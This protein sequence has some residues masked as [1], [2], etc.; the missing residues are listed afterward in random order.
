MKLSSTS[1]PPTSSSG[2]S[3]P[4]WLQKWLITL[5]VCLASSLQRWAGDSSS[6]S[7]DTIHASVYTVITRSV[8]RGGDDHSPNL[9]LLQ[10]LSPPQD[11]LDD[12]NAECQRL[13]RSSNGLDTNILRVARA[14]HIGQVLVVSSSARWPNYYVTRELQH[15][16]WVFTLFVR[17]KGSVA[18]CTG[19]NCLKPSA[20]TASNVL[21]RRAG[22]RPC[23]GKVSYWM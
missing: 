11:D 19:V 13:T 2:G 5:K 8:P 20:S 12:W 3:S 22:F 6:R 1:V 7:A 18:A 21:S 4:V 9:V 10:R 23:R 16:V 15:G 14:T 17:N